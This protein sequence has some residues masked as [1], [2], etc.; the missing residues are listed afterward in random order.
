MFVYWAGLFMLPRILSGTGHSLPVRGIIVYP[1]WFVEPMTPEVK[2]G[3]IWVLNP[4][5]MLSIFRNTCAR[6]DF[7][8]QQQLH[9]VDFLKQRSRTP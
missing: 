6:D 8:D 2:R 9:A 1:G 3:S 5:A 4:M 7:T